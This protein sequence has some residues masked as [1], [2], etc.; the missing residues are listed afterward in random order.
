[1]P[2][3]Q[4]YPLPVATLQDYP[5]PTAT[6]QNYPLPVPNLQNYPLLLLPKNSSSRFDDAI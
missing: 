6:L 4:D 1:M 3:L 5:L 2:N